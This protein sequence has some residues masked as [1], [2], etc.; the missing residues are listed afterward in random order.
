[1]GSLRDEMLKAGLVSKKDAKR[2]A[3][4]QRVETKE[5]GREEAERRAAEERAAIAKQAEAQRIQDRE[6]ALKAHAEQSAKEQAAGAQA[7]IAAQ[8]ESA[9][10]E[11]KVE[12]WEGQRTYYFLAGERELLFLNVSDDASRRLSEGKAAIVRSADSKS[13]YTLLHAGAAEKLAEVAPER[14]VTWHR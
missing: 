2:A 11:G 4:T 13:P 10:R 6:T 14:I 5:T 3:H 8:I 12:H 1:M 9:L 7:R